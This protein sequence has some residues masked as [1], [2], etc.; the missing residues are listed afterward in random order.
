MSINTWWTKMSG[1]AHFL[2]T[3]SNCALDGDS[4]IIKNCSAIPFFDDMVKL[5]KE[6]IA[7]KSANI[8]VERLN[9]YSLGERD[10]DDFFAIECCPDETYFPRKNFNKTDFLVQSKTFRYR[11]AV[12][13]IS[14]ADKNNENKLIDFFSGYCRKACKIHDRMRLILF[15]KDNI[16]IRQLRGCRII[17]YADYATE[18]DYY[19][20]CHLLMTE[21]SGV[22]FNATIKQYI[23]ELVALLCKEKLERCRE[24]LY[25]PLRLAK[26]TYNYLEELFPGEYSQGEISKCLWRAQ[27]KYLFPVL[28][29]YRCELAER[30]NNKLSIELPFTVPYGETINKAEELELANIHY[31][32]KKHHFLPL[33]EEEKWKKYIDMRNDLAHM[34]P[35]SYD[36][37]A[38]CLQG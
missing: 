2:K 12:V 34:K 37:V 35:T 6:R 4:V 14:D 13:I 21:F 38:L 23:A 31:I 8:S 10:I 33:N 24:V 22:E 7:R 17:D 28:E 16:K 3:I 11:N 18:Y 15:V 32:N 19:V 36:N 26:D 29:S 25:E 5:I 1:A 9:A 20:Y 27:I 30:W